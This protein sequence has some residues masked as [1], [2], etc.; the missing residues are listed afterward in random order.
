MTDCAM[1]KLILYSKPASD[2]K[3]QKFSTLTWLATKKRNTHS[4]RPPANET[5]NANLI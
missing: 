3:N 1:L 2:V 5:K 4:D